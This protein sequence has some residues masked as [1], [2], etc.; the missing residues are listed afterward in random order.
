M[1]APSMP[2]NFSTGTITATSAA[3]SWTAGADAGGAVASYTVQMS[4]DEGQSWND[5]ATGMTGTSCTASSLSPSSIYLFQVLAINSAGTSYAAGPIGAKTPA[6]SRGVPTLSVSTNT[7]NTVFAPWTSGNSKG[8]GKFKG[9]GKFKGGNSKGSGVF[10]TLRR[11]RYS[12]GHAKAI[13]FSFGRNGVSCAEP[14]RGARYDI[15]G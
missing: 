1:A 4:T 9:V 15:R 6:L 8:S 10:D 11:G 2:S 7:Q 12:F 5:V 14:G 13:A 3:L